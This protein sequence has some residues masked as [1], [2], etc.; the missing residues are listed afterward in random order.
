MKGEGW[1]TEAEVEGRGSV[2]DHFQAGCLDHLVEGGR[3]GDVRDDGDG[4][5][6]RGGLRGVG[7]AD[8]GG[9]V[10]V[11]DRGHDAVALGEELLEDVG[12]DEAGAPWSVC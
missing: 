8:L 10:L 6:A 12:G 11:A 5:G 9:L 1:R 4:E 3:D 7:F 2:E